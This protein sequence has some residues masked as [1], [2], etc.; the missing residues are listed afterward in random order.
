[1]RLPQNHPSSRGV[2]PRQWTD[3]AA[4]P[5]MKPPLR[6]DPVDGKCNRDVCLSGACAIHSCKL[7]G[8]ILVDE[9]QARAALFIWLEKESGRNVG[10]LNLTAKCAK[11]CW[12]WIY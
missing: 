5:S 10:I 11:G 8:Q 1:M 3:D 2:R 4:I 12:K 9:S 6:T 7:S